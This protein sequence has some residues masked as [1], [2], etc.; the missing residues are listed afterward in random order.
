MKGT[1]SL[2]STRNRVLIVVI[3]FLVSL[4]YELWRALPQGFDTLF[5]G[6]P[7]TSSVDRLLP[8]LGSSD[9]GS[10][11]GAALDL[12][13]GSISQKYIWVLRLWPPGM[14]YLLASMIK[15]GGGASPVLPMVFLLCILWSLVL[16]AL[17]GIFLPRRGYV[18]FAVFSVFWLFSPIF[19][20]WTIQGGVL[21]SDG[22]ATALGT[23]VTIGLVWASFVGPGKRPRW[24]LYVGLGIGLAALAYLRIMWFY[25]VPAALGVLAVLAVGRI[26]VLTIR[27]RFAK[28]VAERR[29]YIEWAALGATFIALCIP[30]TI[31]GETTLHPG[32]YSWSQ[33]DYQWSQEWMSDDYLKANGA[34]FLE[35]GGA[36]WPCDLDPTH[37]KA[38][39][40]YE[41]STSTPYGGLPPNT[42]VKFQHDSIKV[43]IAQPGPFIVDR[44][45]VMLRAWLSTPGGGVG[46]MDNLVYGGLTL[47]ALL[48]ALVILIWQSIRQRIAPLVIFLII[49]ANI[50]VVWLTHFETRYMVPL[51]AMS[52]V[53]VAFAVL[54][55]EA[56]QW[57]SISARR[58]RIDSS[59][60]IERTAL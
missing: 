26:I 47:A 28:I 19:T 60:P 11:L 27:R 36:N 2:T 13:D 49:G 29:S 22:L 33:G 17:A 48:A 18:A 58:S 57:R 38:I 50:G 24:A 44:S 7:A 30:W 54:P 12:Q 8:A 46:T 45:G 1:H 39:A 43:A 23:L 32:N 34:A 3:T 53:V 21:G 40:D 20:A 25:A 41:L 52:L 56:R 9:A 14:P 16:A 35:S 51:Q 6:V 31:Y 42:F 59:D 5:F 55:F 10:Y 4:A 37:C 15:L